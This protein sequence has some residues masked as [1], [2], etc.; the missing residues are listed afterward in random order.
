MSFF[1]DHPIV[2]LDNGKESLDKLLKCVKSSRV[3]RN[4]INMEKWTVY[5]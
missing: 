1:T 4:K 2:D 3:S 5:L